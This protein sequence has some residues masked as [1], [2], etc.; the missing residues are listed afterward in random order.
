MQGASKG[1]CMYIY[2]DV[3]NRGNIA[4]TIMMLYVRTHTCIHTQ[5]HVLRGVVPHERRVQGASE[6]M[7]TYIYIYMYVYIS[8]NRHAYTS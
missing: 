5:V 6:G 3:R 1:T 2:V 4:D 8:N 7:C